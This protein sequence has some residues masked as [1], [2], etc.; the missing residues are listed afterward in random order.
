L[1]VTSVASAPSPMSARAE[2]SSFMN[3]FYRD[4]AGFIPGSLFGQ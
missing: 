2:S 4:R 3:Q 1:M